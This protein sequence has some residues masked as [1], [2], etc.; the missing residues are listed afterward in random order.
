MKSS[1]LVTIIIPS[2][3]S[4]TSIGK[5]LESISAQ[6]FSDYEVLVMDGLSEDNTVNIIKSFIERNNRIRFISEKD[7]G[8]YDAMNKG[9]DKAKG[10]WL[11]F[12]GSDDYLLNN[13]V[14]QDLTEKVNLADYDYVYGNVLSPEYGEKYDGVFDEKKILSQNI[15][16]QALF[17]RKKLLRRFGKFKIRYRLLADYDFN[18]RCMFDKKVRKKYVDLM[19]A[20]YAPAGSSSKGMDKLFLKEKEWLMLKY[21]FSFFSWRERFNLLRQHLKH[22]YFPS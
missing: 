13:S 7:R 4:E 2:F 6:I 15:C 21:G 19:I 16:H 20:Y 1:V 9:I 22:I 12:L 10:E 11:Y 14:L 18:L 8:I 3:N 17:V 5:C